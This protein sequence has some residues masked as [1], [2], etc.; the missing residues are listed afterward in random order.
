MQSMGAKETKCP[1]CGSAEG[2]MKKGFTGAGSQRRFC[3]KCKH[4]YTPNPKKRAYTE[5]ERREAAAFGQGR[6]KGVWDEQEQRVQVEE[7]KKSPEVWTSA[8]T[9]LRAFELDELFWF[10]GSRKGS[11][12]GINAY[13]MTMASRFPRQIVAFMAEASVK[14]RTIQ[15]MVDVAPA[16]ENYFT[17]G[18]TVYLDVDFVGRHRRNVRDKSETHG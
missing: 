18:G 3:N 7:E 17:D 12:S 9:G 10:V 6:W 11:E 15:G 2:Q 16:A 5:E 1:K 8:S 4:K 13:V 14:A